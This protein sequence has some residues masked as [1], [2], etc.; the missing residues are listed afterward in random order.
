MTTASPR[1]GL[2]TGQALRISLVGAG[3]WARTAHLTALAER[4]GVEFAGV[5]DPDRARA[6]A[7][8][9]EFGFAATCDSMDALL[10]VPAD[11]CIIASPAAHHADQALAAL[12]SGRH[13]LL[14][15]PMTNSADSAWDIA[16]E[17][18]ERDLSVMLAFGWNYSAVFEAATRT[19]TAHPIG[20]LEHALLHMASGTHDLL[21]GTSTNSSG[22]D[23]RPAV[24]ATWTDPALSGGGYGNAQLSHGLGLLFGLVDAAASDLAVITRPGPRPGIELGLGV[25]GRLG[26][27][28]TLAVSATSYR[29]PVRQQLDLR[30]FGSQGFLG[31]DLRRDVVW[32]IGADGTEVVEQLAAGAGAY[33]GTAPAR[34]FAD[35]LTGASTLNAS[36]ATVGARATELLD[37]VRAAA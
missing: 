23:D 13:V 29:Q 11:A 4:G 19:L 22:R 26:D 35:L 7:T 17:A 5:F 16:R 25:V 9:D 20:E 31:L 34:A 10:A 21:S 1:R 32:R 14:E 36:D 37:A 6:S 2:D 15:K 27:A 3:A 28:A 8:A 18:A 33:P 24:S 30:L 12:R